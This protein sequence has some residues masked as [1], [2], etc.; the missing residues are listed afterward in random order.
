MLRPFDLSPKV[1]CVFGKQDPP[2]R[3]L[4]TVTRRHH[5]GVQRLWSGPLDHGGPS[6]P[7]VTGQA[8]QDAVGFFSDVNSAVRRDVLVGEIPYR[9]VNYAEDQAFGRDVIESGL[10]KVY[11]PL[12]SVIHSHSYPPFSVPAANV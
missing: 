1:A 7:N 9:D 12:G 10:Y 8:A 3:L 5:Q 11:A 6:N 2:P 4:P